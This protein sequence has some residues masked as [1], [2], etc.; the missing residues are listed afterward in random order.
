M[1]VHRRLATVVGMTFALAGSEALAQS[2][3]RRLRPRAGAARKVRSLWRPGSRKLPLGSRDPA[4]LVSPHRKGGAEFVLV[5]AAT[6]R[7]S[8]RRSI[9]RASPARCH[10]RSTARGPR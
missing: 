5:D 6:R 7:R 2:D 4:L 8:A 3:A 1:T 10:V 9:M